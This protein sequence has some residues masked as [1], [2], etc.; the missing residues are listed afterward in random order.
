MLDQFYARRYKVGLFADRPTI[1]EALQYGTDVANQFKGADK[2]AILTA[3]HVLSNTMVN[4]MGDERND[5]EEA[6][7]AMFEKGDQV[8]KV[9][10]NDNLSE[11]IVRFIED[12]AVNI[13]RSYYTNDEGDAIGTAKLDIGLE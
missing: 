13:N 12:G 10:Y 1:E 11:F 7:I 9:Y 3:L 5:D 8:S 4:I 2:V 6:C